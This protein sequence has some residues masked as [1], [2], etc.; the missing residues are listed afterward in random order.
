[1]VCQSLSKEN[2]VLTIDKDRPIQDIQLSQ[3]SDLDL[4]DN[5]ALRLHDLLA[6]F[7]IVQHVKTPTHRGG[8][9]LTFPD[10]APDKV[11]VD[12]FGMFSDHALVTC[13]LLASVG[14]ATTAERLVRRWRRVDRAVL[15]RAPEDSLT[16]STC[17]G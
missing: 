1:M 11:S 2:G 12:P 4:D 9:A 3:L 13:R 17:A 10:Y 16:M 14:Q 15:R 7:D 5:D 8:S 6:T